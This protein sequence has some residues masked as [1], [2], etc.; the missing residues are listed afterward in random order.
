M[1]LKMLEIIWVQATERQQSVG[2]FVDWFYF[3]TPTHIIYLHIHISQA[4][5]VV[6]Q[7]TSNLHPAGNIQ[8]K[9]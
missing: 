6:S 9:G 1:N 5:S 3:Y 8:P 4:S 7:Y 2:S